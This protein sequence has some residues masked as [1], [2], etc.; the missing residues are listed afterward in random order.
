MKV[1]KNLFTLAFVFIAATCVLIGHSIA[2]HSVEADERIVR[3]GIKKAKEMGFNPIPVYIDEKGEI[4]IV[5]GTSFSIRN[6]SWALVNGDMLINVG[7]RP[8]KAGRIVL[9]TGEYATIK[10]GKAEKQSG[11]LVSGLDKISETEDNLINKN[12][13]KK[14]LTKIKL[15][16]SVINFSEITKYMA[17]DSYFQLVKIPSNRKLDGHFDGQGRIKVN[18]TLPRVKISSNGLFDGNIF[19]LDPGE[20]TIVPQLFASGVYQTSNLVMTNSDALLYPFEM[21]TL[22]LRKI[23][24]KSIAIIRVPNNLKKTVFIDIGEVV[25]PLPTK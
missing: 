22:F 9:N 8:V 13:V 6:G 19:S 18:S 2:G 25:I 23:D 5:P 1:E 11:S 3:A 16:G 14:M 15:A 21:K 24:D 12:M 4:I 10:N 7:S 20:Y 17:G